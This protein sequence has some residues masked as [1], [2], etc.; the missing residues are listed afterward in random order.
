V[1]ERTTL[2][3]IARRVEAVP[4]QRRDGVGEQGARR[5]D[6][7]RE[8]VEDRRDVG[9]AADPSAEFVGAKQRGEEVGEG[10]RG[11]HG[12]FVTGRR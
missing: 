8:R 4:R 7:P 5:G 12:G 9:V 1:T 6:L 3:K 10:C 11:S 2:R